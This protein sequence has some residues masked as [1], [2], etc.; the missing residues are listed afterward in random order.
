MNDVLE[1]VN[2]KTK[3]PLPEPFAYP[4]LSGTFNF[5]LV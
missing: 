1:A 4:A 2:K 3:G 5:N